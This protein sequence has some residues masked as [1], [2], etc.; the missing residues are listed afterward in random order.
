MLDDVTLDRGLRLG[1]DALGFDTPTDVQQQVVPSALT[2]TDLTVTAAT[3]SGKTLAYL[4]PLAQRILT[5][6]SRPRTGTLA[7]VLVPTRE[8]ARQVL[9]HC[10][11]LLDKTPLQV[12]AITGG[13]DFKYQSS[14]LR[15]DPEIVIATPGRLLEH[16]QRGSAELASVQTLVLDEADRM[17]DLG[18]RDDVG[19]IAEHCPEQRQVLM[20]SATAGHP[21]V[22]KV[23]QTLLNE[24][25]EIALAAPRQAHS[26]IYH[27]MIL[28]DSQQHKDKLLIALM[29]A[30]GFQRALVFANKRSTAAR[31]AD[32]LQHHDLRSGCLH[33]EL[34]TEE[35]KHVMA[36]YSDNRFAILCASDVAARGLDVK[37]IDLVVNYDMPHSGD[38]YVHRTGRTARAGA[39]GLAISLVAAPEWNLMI[40]ISRYLQLEFERRALPGLKARYNGP[41]KMKSSGKAAGSK[42]KK[43]PAAAKAKSRARNQKA[44]GRRRGSEQTATSDRTAK[45]DAANKTNKGSVDGFAP[46]MKKKPSR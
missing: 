8:L 30:G 46:L 32:L 28:A 34:S 22:R 27:Q 6:K 20:L 4:I 24:P 44:K 45:S 9:K 16:C 14:L 38:D 5:M 29:R 35:R 1:L 23:A 36:Q 3:G 43:K 37:G 25:Q 12:Q 40:S 41:K 17:L 19:D 15:K 10:R 42:K 26:D 33:G 18:F 13:A 39:Q 2:G 11:Q 7:V 31:L 21:G